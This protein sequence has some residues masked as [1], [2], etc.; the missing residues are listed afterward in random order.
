MVYQKCII[1]DGT[2]F[3]G[4][5]DNTNEVLYPFLVR[6]FSYIKE[7]LIEEWNK[8]ERND[9]YL[10]INVLFE[11]FRS[12]SDIVDHLYLITQS[13][14]IRKMKQHNH[15]EVIYYLDPLLEHLYH[16]SEEEKIAF[17]KVMEQVL[18]QSTGEIYRG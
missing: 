5:N 8:G 2:F 18:K 9:G 10:A 3:R 6:S 17:K 12:S 14:Q 16:L 7:K 11:P 13:I 1:K 4:D 15:Q